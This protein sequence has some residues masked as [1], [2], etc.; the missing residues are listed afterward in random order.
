M[1]NDHK[2]SAVEQLST[3]EPKWIPVEDLAKYYTDRKTPGRK[4]PEQP[5]LDFETLYIDNSFD[6]IQESESKLGDNKEAGE[7]QEAAKLA[8]EST[9][10]SPYMT[11]AEI[12]AKANLIIQA[13]TGSEDEEESSEEDEEK[14]EPQ[15][16]KS[17]GAKYK[18]CDECT[19]ARVKCV[20]GRTSNKDGSKICLECEERGRRC[21]FSV[22]GQRP[23][24]KP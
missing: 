7:N 19:W 8:K 9:I 17:N 11:E 3:T 12:E 14:Q 2:P 15:T 13:A 22:K 4:Y 1:E 24:K 21:H 6:E 10:K 23:A 20:L 18:S 16:K 5:Q